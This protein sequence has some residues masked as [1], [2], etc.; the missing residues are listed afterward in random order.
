M[1]EHGQIVTEN[2]AERS[3]D[4]RG[5]GLASPVLILCGILPLDGF[6]YFRQLLISERQ[7]HAKISR[8]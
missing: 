8:D 5:I 7:R 1:D 6:L 3:V 4:H 2:F